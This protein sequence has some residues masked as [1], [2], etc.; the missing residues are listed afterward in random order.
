MQ[1]NH[2]K[3]WSDN[4]LHEK[5]SSRNLTATAIFHLRDTALSPEK[6]LKIHFWIF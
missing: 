3:A 4:D 2:N 5:M 1:A 6:K